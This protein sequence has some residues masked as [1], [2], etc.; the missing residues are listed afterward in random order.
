M[1][2]A[3]LWR[4]YDR[5]SGSD[6]AA[7]VNDELRFHL[8]SKAEELVAQG[9][10]RED[11]HKEAERQFGNLLAVQRAGE[12][13][14]EH[15]DRRR[16]LR[17]DFAEAR[18]DLRFTLRTLRRDAGFSIIAILILML[19]IGS[20]IAV[21]AVVN[22]LLLRP[23]P[24]PDAHQ[25]L[26]IAPA[27]QKCGFSC[28]TYSAD[29]YNRFREQSISYQD[30]TGYFAFST[31]DNL[32]LMGYGDPQPATGISVIGNFFGV[33]GVRPALGHLFTSDE[34][35]HG[36]GPV[37]VLS[38][39]YWRRQFDS[40]PA[41]VGKAIDLSGQSTTVVGVLPAGFDFGAV[42]SPGGKA[43]LFEPL[44]LED[45]RTMGSIVTM[46]GR[47]KPGA[48]LAQAQAEGTAV[49]HH[50]CWRNDIAASCG[51]YSMGDYPMRLRTLKD[52]VDG[53]F[54]HSLLVLW[55]AV[56][57]ILLIACVNLSNLLLAR[58]AARGKEF[59]VR[60][61]LG[62]SRG[63]IARQLL[64]ES[65]VLSF[66]GALLGLGLAF[67]LLQWL[68]H[69]GS[70]ALPLL[71]SLRID[72]AALEWTALTTVFATLLCGLIPAMRMAGGPLS[73]ALKDSSA[74]AG[75]GRSHQRI[76][77][78]L[79]V[80][81]VA[82]ACMLLIGAGLLLRSF[83]AVLDVD[84]GFQPDRAAAIQIDY[85]DGGSNPNAKQ[86][87]VIARRTA[88]FQ[89][90]LSKISA[91]P[92]VTAAGMVDYLP[93]EQNREWTTPVPKGS[94]YRFGNLPDSLVFVTTPGYFRAMGMTLRG[95]D[96]TWNDNLKSARVIILNEAE[97]RVLFPGQDPIGKVLSA[98]GVDLL[99]VGV[100]KDVHDSNPENQPGWQMYFPA[101]QQGPAGIQLVARTALQ[102]SAMASSVLHA[103]RELNPKQPAAEFRPIRGIV[104][105]AA[106]PRRFFMMLV[107]A[108]AALGLILATL[109]IYGVISYSV[110]RQTQAIG[111]RMALGASMGR[112]RRDVLFDTLRLAS[113]GVV[114]GGAASL[115]SARFISAMLFETSPWD[116]ATYVWMAFVLLAV[117]FVSGYLPAQRAS[118]IDPIQ[119]LRSN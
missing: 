104:D 69:Q 68:A 41:I 83:L 17:D 28:A 100:I 34:M 44:I 53:R 79:V 59:A 117:A 61:A 63:R 43:D 102:P 13:I 55:S 113:A 32:R 50:L 25:L 48:T 106:S 56:G 14:G 92:G 46:L 6:P 2:P 94:G 49:E 47:L 72:G 39:A 8:E 87:D 84:L 107:I 101:T 7:D 11:A 118:R 97:A 21:F 75:Q 96:F 93:M 66:A 105:H 30:I 78:V 4:R 99:V 90:I 12:R 64:T 29:A 16:R 108:F 74:G 24:F 119:A 27:P 10:S 65:L 95:R 38:N 110:T 80:S 89:T 70:L 18:Q 19:A 88:I 111:I 112:V 81:E 37:A 73:E 35:R 116:I 51:F 77:S 115:A 58:A 3:P 91:L 98:G 71:S 54:R 9:W 42:F 67:L 1:S 26:W 57:V 31:A 15:M 23:L 5:L 109:G 52:Y 62:A 82:L 33:L 103:L 40:D 45:A 36:A 85:D 20:N 86:E 22:T 114:L 76:R 60:G